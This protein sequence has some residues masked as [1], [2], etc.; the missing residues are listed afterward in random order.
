MFVYPMSMLMFTKKIRKIGNTLIISIP[1]DIIGLG[2][3][4]A[5]DYVEIRMKVIKANP[6]ES[7]GID[8]TLPD[9]IPDELKKAVIEI[10]NFWYKLE[11]QISKVDYLNEV[12]ITSKKI[13]DLIE[14][15]KL[16]DLTG[17]D[18][19]KINVLI[20][21][22]LVE[23]GFIEYKRSTDGNLRRIDTEILKTL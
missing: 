23:C 1:K 19:K 17:F 20:G 22:Y 14:D 11:L 6:I 10:L 21:N 15:Q 8:K 3:I 5:G 4:E 12:W 13:R 2:H 16:Y 18:D 9:K 7:E